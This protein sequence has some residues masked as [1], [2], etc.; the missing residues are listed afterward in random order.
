MNIH[1]F[2]C[3]GYHLVSKVV[4]FEEGGPAFHL[5][6]DESGRSHF[7]IASTEVVVTETGVRVCV[8]VCVRV[9]SRELVCDNIPLCNYRSSLEYF[10][11]LQKTLHHCYF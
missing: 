11:Q 4:Q 3:R 1:E 5:C 8:C 7:Y 6:L 9:R 2:G 10:R